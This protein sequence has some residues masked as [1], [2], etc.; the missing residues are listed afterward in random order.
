MFLSDIFYEPL[1]IS[2]IYKF[3]SLNGDEKIYR[4]NVDRC[5]QKSIDDFSEILE[6]SNIS[7]EFCYY[8]MYSRNLTINVDLTYIEA[9]PYDIFKK[10]F[11]L[12]V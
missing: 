12:F 9:K 3:F 7:Y 6:S 5:S 4:I 2:I 8:T 11:H 1:D 10:Y